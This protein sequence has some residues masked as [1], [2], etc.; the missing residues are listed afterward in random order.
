M[1]TRTT[2]E[3]A[4]YGPKQKVSIEEALRIWTIGSAYALFMED[5]IGS[6]EVGKKADFVV[7]SENP[8]DTDPFRLKD[9]EVLGTAVGGKWVYRKN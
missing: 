1:V 9:I 6:L 8:L 2:A 4:L 7:L 5:T 3:G